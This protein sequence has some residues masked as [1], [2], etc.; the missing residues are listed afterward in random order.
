MEFHKTKLL[1]GEVNVLFTGRNYF[2]FN[3]FYGVICVAE[4]DDEVELSNTSDAQE[5]KSKFTL[6]SGHRDG[7]IQNECF[8]MAKRIIKKYD[9]KFGKK[10]FQ[11]EEVVTDLNKCSITVNYDLNRFH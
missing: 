11:F 3:G 1:D 4:R 5:W 6:Y 8:A 2:F 7:D 9:Q 10:V